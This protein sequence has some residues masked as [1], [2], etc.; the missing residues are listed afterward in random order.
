MFQLVFSWCRK[1]PT[2]RK[3]AFLKVLEYTYIM[4]NLDV[5]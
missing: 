2:R 1:N 3:F 5:Q 4:E